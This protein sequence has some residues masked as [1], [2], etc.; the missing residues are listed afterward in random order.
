MDHSSYIQV[1]PIDIKIKSN[2]KYAS[3]E[4]SNNMKRSKVK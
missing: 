1:I 3:L 4:V 2:Y